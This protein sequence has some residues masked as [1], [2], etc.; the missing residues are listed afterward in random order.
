MPASRKKT[1]RR[2]TATISK[3]GTRRQVREAAAPWSSRGAPLLLDT[4]SWLWWKAG[5]P[6]LGPGARQAIVRAT[7]VRFSLASA[8]EIAIK[9]AIRKLTIPLDAGFAAELARHSFLPLPIEFRHVEALA[10]L[11]RVHRDP[12]DRMLAAQALADGLTVVTADP[13]FSRY[14]VAVLAAHA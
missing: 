7:E 8:W 1:S 10:A 2:R 14:G 6:R 13:V 4:H 12:F 5:D 3:H 9:V 11:P